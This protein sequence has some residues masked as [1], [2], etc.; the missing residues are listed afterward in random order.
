M[1]V[2]PGMYLREPLHVFYLLQDNIADYSAD[3]W[4][5]KEQHSL[6]LETRRKMLY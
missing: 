3:S 5:A 1:I 2:G 6:K 4:F